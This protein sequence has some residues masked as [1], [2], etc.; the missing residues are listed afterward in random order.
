MQAERLVMM[1][2]QIAGFFA[3]EGMERGAAQTANHLVKFWDPRM[4]R[5]IVAHLE[6]GGAGLAPVGRQA[7]TLLSKETA[8]P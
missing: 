7:V 5:A 8:L 1:V 2:N 3:R 6:A 4:R